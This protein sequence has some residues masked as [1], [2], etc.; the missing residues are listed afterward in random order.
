M[1]RYAI[2]CRRSQER[3]ERQI[4]SLEDQQT[5]AYRL[6]DGKQLEVVEELAESISAKEPYRRPGF[7]R[8]ISLV[9]KGVI[10][11]IITWHPDRLSRNEVDAASVTYL[12]RKGKLLDLQFGNYSF[13][14]SP[15]GIMM[16]QMALS[17]SQ[18]QSSK[19]A[20]DVRRG[21]DSKADKG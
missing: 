19:L 7:S 17:Q 6:R 2:Y 10:N 3:D 4:Q 18:Y 13:D 16:L 11:G 9:E 21:V 12:I 14:N 8:L 15:E 1:V 20:R 5:V